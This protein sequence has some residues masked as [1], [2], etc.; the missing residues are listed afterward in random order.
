MTS[1]FA[2]TSFYVAIVNPKDASH[3]NAVEFAR[4]FQGIIVTTEYVLIELGNWLCRSG[5]K[6]VFV[7]LIRK[8][9]SDVQTVIVQADHAWFE[10]GL[11]LYANRPDKDWSLTDCISFVVMQDQGIKE[12]LTCDHHFEQ[13]SFIT[14][15]R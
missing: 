3:A 6:A 5:D 8:L 10:H 9:R 12:A 4:H 7:E 2:D 11:E 15:L 14:L 1:V 13:A